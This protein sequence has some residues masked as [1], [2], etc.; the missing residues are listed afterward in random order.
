MKPSV[1]F[2][3]GT[4]FAFSSLFVASALDSRV[5][6]SVFLQAGFFDYRRVVLLLRLLTIR[7]IPLVARILFESISTSRSNWRARKRR[8]GPPIVSVR[9][10]E[11]EVFIE[12]VA[13]SRPDLIVSINGVAK[14]S[15]DLLAVAKVGCLNVHLGELPRYRGLSPVV[16]AVAAGED[17]VCV[18]FHWMDDGLDTGSVLQTHQ[19]PIKQANSLL[20]IYYS[21][22]KLAIAQLGA[23]IDLAMSPK[24]GK[25]AGRETDKFP[26]LSAPAARDVRL[27]KRRIVQLK[28]SKFVV[29]R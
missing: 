14:W 24:I 8:G 9:D 18:T 29:A 19:F 12:S 3:I 7:D 6:S 2:V 10:I 22:N 5:A 16:H 4:D 23:A 20:G 27:A 15:T 13:R 1:V 17:T 26:Y 11:D 25:N 21:L 28:K